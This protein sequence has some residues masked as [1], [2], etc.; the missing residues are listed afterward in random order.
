M[1]LLKVT[2]LCDPQSPWWKGPDFLT[3]GLW[4]TG[5][6]SRTVSSLLLL[7]K[8]T[9]HQEK[10]EAG[11]QICQNNKPTVPRAWQE[12][13]SLPVHGPLLGRNSQPQGSTGQAADSLG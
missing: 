7:I 11:F 1:A 13:Q 6:P 12:A 8:R 10:Q 5:Y 4:N 3:V 2:E 9:P